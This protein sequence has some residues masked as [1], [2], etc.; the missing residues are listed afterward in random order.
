M[1]GLFITFEGVDGCGKS[2]QMRFLSEYLQQQG[3]SPVLTREPGGCNIAEK[4]RD[5]VLDIENKEMSDRTEALL[6]AAARAQHVKQVIEPAVAAGK[7]VLCDRFI[8]SSL[9]YQ[10]VGRGLGVESV[11]D[12]NCF[13]MG[14]RM[15]DKTFFLDFPPH[16]AFERMSKKRVHDR[17]E[18]Q[19]EE[20]YILL[21]NGF[22]KLSEMYPERIIRI[23][24]SGDKFATQEIVR[25]NMDGILK[26]NGFR[27]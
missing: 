14:D 22:V 6:Y 25:A 2:T 12:I 9:A 1:K 21:Y 19:E 7:I 3:I 26:E 23:D 16:L 4:I 15:P 10:G 13:A 18:T 27:V 17:L 11:M 24:A 8:D 20:F 5:L